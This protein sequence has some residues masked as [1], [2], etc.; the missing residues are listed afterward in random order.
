MEHYKVKFRAYLAEKT[1]G[2]I[3]YVQLNGSKIGQADVIECARKAIDCWLA[4]P[5]PSY[6]HFTHARLLQ[7]QK[8]ETVTT[9]IDIPIPIPTPI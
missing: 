7:I 1:T 9:V 5:R 4:K 8:V 2:E 3:R 6:Q